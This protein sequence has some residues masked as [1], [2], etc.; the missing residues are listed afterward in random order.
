MTKFRCNACGGSY[1]DVQPDG[2]AYYHACPPGTATPRDENIVAANV[3][4]H[5]GRLFELIPNPDNPEKPREVPYVVKIRR[6]GQG[7]TQG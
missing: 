6:E 3:T 7:R 4:S 5:D 1:T 2:T